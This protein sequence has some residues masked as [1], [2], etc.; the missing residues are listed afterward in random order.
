MKI[1]LDTSCVFSGLYSSLGASY[2]ILSLV[3]KGLIIPI[4][5]NPL[6][7]EYEDVLKRKC[8]KLGLSLDEI[9]QFLNGICAVGVQKEVSF[10]WRP[11]LRDADDEHILEL[12]VVSEAKAIVTHNIR[13]FFGAERFGVTIYQPSEFLTYWRKLK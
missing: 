13:D 12:A 2:H 1:I 4:L 3:A 9:D 11:Q 5:S 8:E 7:Y 6:I 10:M